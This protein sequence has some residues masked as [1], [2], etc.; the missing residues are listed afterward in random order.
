[1]IHPSG[2]RGVGKSHGNLVL[3]RF[4]ENVRC[5]RLGAVAGDD[6]DEQLPLQRFSCRTVLTR[7]I[8][9]AA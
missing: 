2:F 1:M 8:L 5:V 6:K 7:E 9:H 3:C 4:P